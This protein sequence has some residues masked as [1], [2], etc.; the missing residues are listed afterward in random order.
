[1]QWYTYVL[2]RYIWERER[3]TDWERDIL[4]CPSYRPHCPC[5]AFVSRSPWWRGGRQCNCSSCWS[6]PARTS[7]MCSR[8]RSQSMEP[9]WPGKESGRLGVWWAEVVLRGSSGELV[10]SVVGGWWRSW[11]RCCVDGGWW[12]TFGT[13]KTVLSFTWL[14]NNMYM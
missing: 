12:Y 10:N 3:E 6:G 5:S 9:W 13:Q 1:M 7:V 14:L 2:Y 8:C 4:N 11:W